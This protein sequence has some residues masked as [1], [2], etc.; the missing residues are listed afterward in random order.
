MVLNTHQRASLVLCSGEIAYEEDFMD[1][2]NC[3]CKRFQPS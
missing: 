3:D 1:C 2:F